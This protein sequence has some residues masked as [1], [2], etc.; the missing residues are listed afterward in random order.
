MQRLLAPGGC[1][2][3]GRRGLLQTRL[4]RAYDVLSSYS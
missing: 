2:Y 3:L 4:R 1:G